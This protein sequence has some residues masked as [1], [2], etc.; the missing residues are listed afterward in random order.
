MG[1]TL[2]RV[3]AVC[4][5]TAITLGA[6][7]ASRATPT[8]R[9]RAVIGAAFLARSQRPNGSL[10]AFSPIGSTADAVLA[11][12]AAGAERR[13]TA[14]AL[15][16]LDRQVSAGHV[17]GVGLTA[18]VALAV[19]AMGRDPRAFA[20]HNLIFEIRSTEDADG[21][22][23]DGTAAVLDEA[24]AILAFRGAD[25]RASRDALAWLR[26]AQ[27]PDGGW[28]YDEPYDQT[29]DNLHC[30]SMSAP[31]SDFFL[32]DTNTTAYVVQAL[33]A[34]GN[35]PYTVN[36]FAF[37]VAIRDPRRG[38]WGYTWGLRGT[39]ANSTSLALQAYAA[40]GLVTPHGARAALRGLQWPNSGGWAFT[41]SGAQRGPADVGATIGAIPGLLG[42]PFPLQ[43]RT[44]RVLTRR[45]PTRT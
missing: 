26:A 27:C 14:S 32:S 33:E 37:F 43:P 18:K 40:A 28:A 11:F 22:F 19:A 7:L 2:R 20:G 21:R 8:D 39:D 41:W 10:P 45:A 44:L 16:Y 34:S 9:H 15:G 17:T 24:L 31:S 25:T 5:A 4:A 6:P 36:P 3:I 35:R 42:D 23:G 29:D 12:V 13:A 30:R 38:G 1:Q